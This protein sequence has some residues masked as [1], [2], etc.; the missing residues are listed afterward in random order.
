MF[1]SFK[2]NQIPLVSMAQCTC[3]RGSSVPNPNSPGP[4]QLNGFWAF[5]FTSYSET[6]LPHR[7]MSVAI[8]VL[9]TLPSFPGDLMCHIQFN[10]TFSVCLGIY[11]TVPRTLKLKWWCRSHMMLIIYRQTD[12]LCF[13]QVIKNSLTFH[14]WQSII[15]R[16][17]MLFGCIYLALWSAHIVY[18]FPSVL[19]FTWTYIILHNLPWP[20]SCS[21]NIYCKMCLSCHLYWMW[22]NAI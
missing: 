12:A 2:Q 22:N 16:S 1:I 5:S 21:K 13:L 9:Q 20:K 3:R 6:F 15:L 18:L 10:Q 14:C 4:A 19:M 8:A 17:M 11:V 7:Q